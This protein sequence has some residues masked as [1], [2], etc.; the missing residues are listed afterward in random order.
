MTSL[1]S[2]TTLARDCGMRAIDEDFIRA[3]IASSGFN[4]ILEVLP[5]LSDS[6]IRELSAAIKKAVESPH[7]EARWLAP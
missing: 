6:T 4:R 2:H 7:Q 5:V 1:R 3:I